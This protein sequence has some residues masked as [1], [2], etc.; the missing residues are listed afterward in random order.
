MRIEMT[1]RDLNVRQ[2][3]RLLNMESIAVWDHA[4]AVGALRHQLAAQL[5]PDLVLLEV[6][7]T[8]CARLRQLAD[9]YSRSGVDTFGGQLLA[10]A[11]AAEVL[12]AIKEYARALAHDRN[13]PLA[14]APAAILYY[15]AIAAAKLRLHMKITHLPDGELADG[16]TW[17]LAQEGA[18]ALGPLFHKALA[19]L[20]A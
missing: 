16:Y 2:L 17:A 5:L 1:S 12:L 15:A 10:P 3:S 9:E 14:G 6:G 11:P 7:A 19:E 4:D 20:A 13:S 8:A 18:E